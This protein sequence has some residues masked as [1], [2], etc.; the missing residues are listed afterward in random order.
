MSA[1]SHSLPSQS[2]G[3]YRAVNLWV[4]WLVS[5]LGLGALTAVTIWTLLTDKS[6]TPEPSNALPNEAVIAD[7]RDLYESIKEASQF[8]NETEAPPQAA[9][10]HPRI[11]MQDVSGRWNGMLRYR[12]IRGADGAE[13]IS[14]SVNS[15]SVLFKAGLRSGDL[16]VGMNGLAIGHGLSAEESMAALAD[17]EDA[18][19][20]F[21]RNGIPQEMSID[22][23]SM[24]STY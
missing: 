20:T 14:V 23:R 11:E 12:V 9:A 3:R 19:I 17:S 7:P 18:R 21:V 2:H 5:G 10:S 13:A 24:A 1:R 6:T 4:K 15:G 22:I 8:D 16:I